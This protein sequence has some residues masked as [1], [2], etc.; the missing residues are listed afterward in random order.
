M[1]TEIDATRLWQTI[2]ETVAQER[3]SGVG[4]AG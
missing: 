2:L 1:T 4:C 3:P